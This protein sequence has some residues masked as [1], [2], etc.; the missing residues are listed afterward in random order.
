MISLNAQAVRDIAKAQA[1][2]DAAEVILDQ[3]TDQAFLWSPDRGA[4]FAVKLWSKDRQA[5]PMDAL[6]RTLGEPE[7]VYEVDQ[8]ARA[9]A[10]AVVAGTKLSPIVRAALADLAERRRL[11]A[12]HGSKDKTVAVELDA[13]TQT[14]VIGTFALEG[15]VLGSGKTVVNGGYLLACIDHCFGMQAYGV[16]LEIHPEGVLR[17]MMQSPNQQTEPDSRWRGQGI[18]GP[19]VTR[20]RQ[21]AAAATV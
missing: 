15:K 3:G 1:A 19:V 2:L 13:E 17:V 12:I 21:E 6:D 20:T 4:A 7:A 5:V 16:Q 10:A 11:A 18:L 8:L 9:Q 14:V